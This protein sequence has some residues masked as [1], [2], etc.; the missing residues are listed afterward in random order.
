MSEF[1]WIDWNLN[2][3]DA[4][5]LSA[6]EVEFAWHNRRDIGRENDPVHGP[7]RESIGACPSGRA[8]TIV[9]RYN[10][11]GDDQFGVCDYGLLGSANEHAH[12]NRGA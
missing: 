10:Q 3:I 11:V 2:K 1:L 6:D 9:W 8:I 12:K 5:G 4:H 7:S